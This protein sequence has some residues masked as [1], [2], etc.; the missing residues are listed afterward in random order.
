MGIPINLKILC[1]LFGMVKCPFKW[2]SDL[3]IGDEKVTLNHLETSISWNV[4]SLFFCF[5][6]GSLGGSPLLRLENSRNVVVAAACPCGPALEIRKTKRYP[7]VIFYGFY[8]GKITIQ[9]VNFF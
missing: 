7:T 6:C 8:H 4:S 1:D 9:L 3:Q 2:L 5:F